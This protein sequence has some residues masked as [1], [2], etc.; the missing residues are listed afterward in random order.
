MKPLPTEIFNT[1]DLMP[2]P[3][4]GT[5][6]RV[7]VFPALFRRPEPGQVGETLRMDNEAGCFYHPHKKAIIP[8]EMCGRFL[9]DLC[10]FELNGGHLCPSCVEAS[11]KKHKLESLEK[12]RRLYDNI[13]LALACFP[14]LI[15]WLTIL[16]APVSLFVA[17]RHWN[18]PSSI[19]PRTKIRYL[20]AILLATLQM[21]GWG[22]F[23]FLVITK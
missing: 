19:I 14:L 2:C 4:C 20:L 3:Y 13:A 21:A 22:G 12:H 18:S 10:D 6:V 5:A 8:C 1:A 23:I 15:F 16:T 17:I 9:C 11:K 7:D